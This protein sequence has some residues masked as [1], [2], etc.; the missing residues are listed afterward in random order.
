MFLYFASS[1][2]YLQTFIRTNNI[3]LHGNFYMKITLLGPVICH[4]SLWLFKKNPCTY[5]NYMCM[6]KQVSMCKE[7]ARICLIHILRHS[8]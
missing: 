8:D 6:R 5:E 2:D 7:K 4:T 3:I 1:L